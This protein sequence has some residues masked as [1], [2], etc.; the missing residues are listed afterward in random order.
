MA[1]T[2]LMEGG[3]HVV[4]EAIAI[5]VPVIATDI[6]GNRGLLGDEYLGYYPVGDE[7]A[8]A[9]LMQK[10]ENDPAFY[11]SLEKAIQRRR[12]LVQPAFEMRSIKKLLNHCKLI[13]KFSY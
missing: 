6:A 4:T 11:Q 2:S 12:K 5:G 10:A 8:L 13:R 1:I 7:K 9:K 3:A